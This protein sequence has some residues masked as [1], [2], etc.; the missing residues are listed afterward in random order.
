MSAVRTE[1][2][3]PKELAN[4]PT[5]HAAPGEEEI[6]QGDFGDFSKVARPPAEVAE[7][8]LAAVLEERF[9]IE[10]DETYR[11]PIRERHRAIESRTDPPA[12]GLVL[13]PYLG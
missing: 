1:R 12:R 9:W 5:S 11:E 7:L 13:A 10:T 6:S 2:N 3:R 8:V 4:A